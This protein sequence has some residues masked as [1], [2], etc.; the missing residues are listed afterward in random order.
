MRFFAVG[1]VVAGACLVAVSGLFAD[2][3]LYYSALE[4]P[5]LR[6]AAAGHRSELLRPATLTEVVRQY[7]VVCHNDQMR[8]GNVSLQAFDVERAAEQAETA[9]RMIRK[10]RAGMMPPPGMPRPAGD[11]L[12]TLV[13]T[14]ESI[15]DGAARVVPSLGERRFQRLS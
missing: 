10:L 4:A 7:C 12:S 2:P 1:A 9:E 6:A 14:L 5:P 8:S 15:V 11:T 3:S 13:E